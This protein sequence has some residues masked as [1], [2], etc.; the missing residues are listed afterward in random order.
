L[1]LGHDVLQV[2]IDSGLF[3]DIDVAFQHVDGASGEDGDDGEH[4]HDLDEG[5]TGGSAEVA[6]RMDGH[7][8]FTGLTGGED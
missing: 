4:D 3:G 8:F 2:A 6:G 5:E 1:E 7:G